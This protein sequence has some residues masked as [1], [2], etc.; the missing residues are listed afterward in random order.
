MTKQLSRRRSRFFRRLAAL[1]NFAGRS[2]RTSAS[3]RGLLAL[4]ACA[5]INTGYDYEVRGL[6]W[7]TSVSSIANDGR[8][9]STMRVNQSVVGVVLAGSIVERA[10]PVLRA[11]F[12]AAG[13]IAVGNNRYPPH[14]TTYHSPHGTTWQANI[15]V[16]AVSDTGLAVG[17]NSSQQAVEWPGSG[18]PLLLHTPG[19]AKSAAWGV[20]P[21]GRYV[22]GVAYQ[23]PQDQD[24]QACVWD[25]QQQTFTLLWDTVQLIGGGS[26]SHFSLASD[27]NNSGVVV[28][29]INL[30][31]VRWVP[32][33]KGWLPEHLGPKLDGRPCHARSIN[34]HGTIVGECAKGFIWRPG[35]KKLTPVRDL[36]SPNTGFKT[37]LTATSINDI[38][39]IVGRAENT[40][41][42]YH[43]YVMTPKT[44]CIRRCTFSDGTILPIPVSQCT[45]LG[46]Q[47]PTI[48]GQEMRHECH[49]AEVRPIKRSVS[50]LPIP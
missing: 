1:A 22:V 39:Q 26:T 7:G 13:Q 47:H 10:S 34:R 24:G 5:T 11:P 28:G 21:N 27:V 4:V 19:F 48:A 32:T 8:I 17:F 43:S 45:D 25:R 37:Y 15:E 14:G 42:Q 46:G 16:N 50:K 44:A 18:Q 31:A 49:E 30:E 33:P 38:G 29:K 9:G 41:Y 35:A 23:T 2:R 3:A 40:P 36:V 20:S 6:G 12:V